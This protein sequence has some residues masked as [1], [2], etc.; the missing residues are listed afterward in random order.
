[1]K[2]AKNHWEKI[3]FERRLGLGGGSSLGLGGGLG[4]SLGGGLGLGLGGGL[5]L[6]LVLGEI[7]LRLRSRI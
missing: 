4:L 7:R 1:M 3:F 2:K 6:G 5:G